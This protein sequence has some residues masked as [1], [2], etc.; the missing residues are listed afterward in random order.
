MVPRCPVSRCQSP[1]FWWSRDVRSR[2]FSRPGLIQSSTTPD[3]LTVDWRRCIRMEWSTQS[4]ATDMSS[5]LSSVTRL[6]SAAFRK[7]E[8]TR[9]VAVS[10]M[11]SGDMAY[12]RVQYYIRHLCVCVSYMLKLVSTWTTDVCENQHCVAM[13]NWMTAQTVVLI[14]W[15]VR[16]WMISVF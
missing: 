9:S 16:R 7:S 15:R 6:V 12:I 1:Q 3:S 13:T 14:L 2:V 11:T 4:K 10:V 5:R 8:Q